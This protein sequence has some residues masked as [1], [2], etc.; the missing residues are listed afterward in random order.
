MN[1]DFFEKLMLG[2]AFTIFGVVF[3]LIGLTSLIDGEK[4]QKWESTI[5]VVL[6]SKLDIKSTRS[7]GFVSNTYQTLVVY[8]YEWQEIIY[9]GDRIA[10]GYNATSNE[11]WHET[12]Y[13]K[14]QKNKKIKIWVNPENP[15]KSVIVTGPIASMK[16]VSWPALIFGYLVMNIF[17]LMA[18]QDYPHFKTIIKIVLRILAV[19]ML[20]ACFYGISNIRAPSLVDKIE[21]L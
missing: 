6:S 9:K 4:S 1:D 7:D 2:L 18:S 21:V 12:I 15:S 14:L 16:M 11:Q 17:L 5:G 19:I 10:F 3:F 13:K 8:Q 20:I